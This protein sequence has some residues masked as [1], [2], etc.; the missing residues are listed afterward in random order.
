MMR[1]LDLLS[2]ACAL[3]VA[4]FAVVVVVICI[5]MAAP[6]SLYAAGAGAFIVLALRGA[7]LFG[8]GR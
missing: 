5:W 4:I 7:L 3:T 2:Y 6:A 1:L 8:F